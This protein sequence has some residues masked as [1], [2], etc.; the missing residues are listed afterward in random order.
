MAGVDDLFY[1]ARPDGDGVVR[2]RRCAGVPGRDE[3]LAVALQVVLV[4]LHLVDALPAGRAL[5]PGLL[6]LERFRFSS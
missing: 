4:V 1:V 6:K 3:S 2:R 5:E